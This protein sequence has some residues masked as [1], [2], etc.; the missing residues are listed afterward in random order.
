VPRP[1]GRAEVRDW[2]LPRDS[3]AD[4]DPAAH[5]V[6]EA[7]RGRGRGR[8]HETGPALVWR[9]SVAPYERGGG[10]H[11]PGVARAWGACLFA[12]AKPVGR[13]DADS[14]LARWCAGGPSF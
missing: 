3:D 12:R 4:P 5:L 10:L 14:R 6:R 11:A 2:S 13:T 7:W 1:A 8:G 9:P